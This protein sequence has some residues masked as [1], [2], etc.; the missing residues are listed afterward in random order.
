MGPLG[1]TMQIIMFLSGLEVAFDIVKKGS[2][3]HYSP[4]PYI[5]QI[6]NSALWRW[7]GLSGPGSGLASRSLALSGSLSVVV[8]SWPGAALRG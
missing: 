3:G 6:L 2:I 5:V 1:C 7:S 4:F 8:G